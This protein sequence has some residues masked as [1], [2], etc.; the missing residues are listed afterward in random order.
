MYDVHFYKT[1][2]EVKEALDKN[3]TLS[4]SDGMSILKSGDTIHLL[5]TY[6]FDV[7]RV[8]VINTA[9]KITYPISLPS[10]VEFITIPK[11]SV[12]YRYA[13]EDEGPKEDA[14]RFYAESQTFQFVGVASA[15]GS[16][17][18]F[19]YTVQE[20]LR[21][22]NFNKRWRS[23]LW[24]LDDSDEDCK[25]PLSYDAYEHMLY[26]ICAK[27]GAHGWRAA[28][29]NDQWDERQKNKSFDAPKEFEIALFSSHYVKKMELRF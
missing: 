28:C 14:P 2:S 29:F 10:N 11:G 22:V 12:I 27:A 3:G 18:V 17:E 21:I 20:P 4:I 5:L 19:T 23:Q 24:C 8:Y 26:T 1:I 13:K 7:S 9:N 16:G 25:G 6:Y 15:S